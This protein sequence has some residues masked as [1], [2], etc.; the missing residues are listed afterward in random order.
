MSSAMVATLLTK[1]SATVCSFGWEWTRESDDERVIAGI[2]AVLEQAVGAAK[3][4]DLY[5]PFKYMNYAAEDQD[6]V[7]GYGADNVDFLKEVR[8][9]YDSERVFTELVPGWFKVM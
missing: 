2:K 7:A 4:R 6:P 9:M 3:E 1:T 5:H 8:D